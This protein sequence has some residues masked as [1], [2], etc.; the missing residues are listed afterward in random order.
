MN[1]ETLMIPLYGA[2]LCV[3][4]GRTADFLVGRVVLHRHGTGFTRCALPPLDTDRPSYYRRS[5]PHGSHAG[6]VRHFKAGEK[7]C[8][9]CRRA[10]ADYQ[11]RRRAA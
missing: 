1:D 3:E 9:P 7:A 2:V 5:T 10:H 4:C 8:A 11:R 6:Y